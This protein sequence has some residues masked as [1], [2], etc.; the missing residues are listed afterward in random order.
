MLALSDPGHA[1]EAYLLSL[2]DDPRAAWHDATLREL[3]LVIEHQAGAEA[4]QVGRALA[5]QATPGNAGKMPTLPEA[6]PFWQKLVVEHATSPYAPEALLLAAKLQL[7]GD[8]WR[9]AAETCERLV[10]DYPAS[11]WAGDAHVTLIDIKLERL[12]DLE[13]TQRNADAAVQWYEKT[14]PRPLEGGSAPPLFPSD[15]RDDAAGQA[16]GAKSLG[17][18]GRV[19]LRAQSP[20]AFRERVKVRA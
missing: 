16:A 15:G 2:R 3:A 6:L 8:Q 12:L 4:G 11:P 9:L 17:R 10:K 1:K 14:P 20:L 19:R 7:D 13:G 5:R 18:S